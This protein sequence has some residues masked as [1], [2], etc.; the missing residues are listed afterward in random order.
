MKNHMSM[1][2]SLITSQQMLRAPCRMR[3]SK[4]V[5]GCRR[6]SSTVDRG[7]EQRSIPAL[8]VSMYEAAIHDFFF[9]PM[10]T[11]VFTKADLNACTQ[12]VVTDTLQGL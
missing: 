9:P 2:K 10:V 4:R 7:T 5:L 8:A 3:P 11:S 6:V 1:Q 12:L